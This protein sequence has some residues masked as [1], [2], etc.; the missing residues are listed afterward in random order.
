LSETVCLLKSLQ[1]DLSAVQ[2]QSPALLKKANWSKTRV[3]HFWGLNWEVFQRPQPYL[4]YQRSNCSLS[5]F[6]IFQKFR[7]LVSKNT[8]PF[9][10]HM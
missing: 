9:G 5:S 7:T 1:E 4:V 3:P 8:R 10:S 2:D 6:S